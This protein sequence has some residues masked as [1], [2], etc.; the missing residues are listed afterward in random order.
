M[1]VFSFSGVEVLEFLGI[2]PPSFR[3]AAGALLVLPAYR[4]VERGESMEVPTR[5]D[6]AD[7]L[8]VALVPLAIPLLV[9]PGALAATVSFSQTM[10]AGVAVTAAGAVLAGCWLVF[11]AAEAVFRLLG[12]AVL[13]LLTRVVGILLMAI[14]VD[15][16]L[17]GASAF[18]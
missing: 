12:E 17:E 8:A 5:E 2:S 15:F 18:F 16:V 13:R 14:A 1:V 10:G 7:V 9:G 11:V 6:R 3:V 4:M